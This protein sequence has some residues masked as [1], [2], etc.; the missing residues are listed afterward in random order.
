MHLV[1]SRAPIV[2]PPQ[3]LCIPALVA[4]QAQKTPEALAILAPGRSPLTYGRL[5]QHVHEVIPSLRTLGIGCHNRVALVLPNG[6]EMAVA[7]LAISAGAT[8]APLNPAYGTNDFDFALRAVR[9]NTLLIQERVDSPARAVAHALGVRIVEL[10]PRLDAEAGL[11]TLASQAPPQAAPQ[12]FAQ[13]DDVALVLHTTGTT[14]QPKG[15]PLTH[16]NVCVSAYNTRHALALSAR[17][18]CLNVMPLFHAHGLMGALLAS[19]AAGASV[20]CTPGFMAPN[21]FDWVAEYRPTWYTAVPTIHQAI[22]ARAGVHRDIITRCPL[23]FIR[24]GSAA[25]SPDILTQ[26]ETTFQAPVIEYY[27]MT[28]AASQIACNP[29][30]PQVRKPGSVGVAAGPEVAVMDESGTFVPAGTTGEIIIRGPNVMPGYDRDPQA[31]YNAFVSGWFRTGDQGFL[32][33][34]GY[35]FITGRLKEIINRGGEKI[36]PQEVEAVLMQHPAVAQAIAFAVPE[37]RLGEEVAAVVVLHHGTPATAH[38]LRHF[39]ATRL[40]AWKV[41][42]QVCIVEE[43]PRGP[44]GKLQRLHLAAQLGLTAPADTQLPALTDYSPART[45]IEEMLVGL[46]AQMLEVERVGRDDDFFAL[47]G[48]SILATQL[49]VRVREATQVEVSHLSFFEAPTVAGMARSIENAERTAGSLPVPLLQPVLKHDALPLSYP[50]QR[51]WFLEQMGVIG[52]AY[53]LVDAIRLRG[54]LNIMALTQSLQEILSRHAILRTTFTDIEG[55]PRQIIGPVTSLSLSMVDMRAFHADTRETQV[56][57][58]AQAEARRS[59]DLTQGPLLRTTLVHCA[60][61]ESVLILSMHHIVSDGWSHGVWWRELAALYAAFTAGKPSPLPPLPVQYADFAV[62]QRQWIHGEALR[63]S[64]AYWKRHLA[65]VTTLQ[66]P[67]DHPRPPVKT[68]RGARYPLTLSSTLTQALKE[69]SQ[70][71]GRTLFMT[72]LAAF[73]T[74]LHRYTGQEDI[75]VGSLIANRSLVA[76]EALIGFFVNTI[77]LRTD[78][79]GDPSFQEL[80]ARIRAVTLGAYSHRELPFEMLLEELRPPRDLSKTPLFQVLFVLQNAPRSIPALA[81]LHVRPVEVDPTTAR[82]DLTLDL[83]ETS[84]GLQG[85][86]EYSTDLFEATTIARMAGHLQTLLEGVVADPAQCLSRLPLSRV[87]ERQ[88]LLVEWNATHTEYPHDQCLHEAFESQV[89]RTPNA[90]AIGGADGYLSYSELNRR[91]NQV[92]HMLRTLD[93]GAETLVGLCVERSLLM[94][95]GL[96][97]ILKAGAG[98]VPLDPTYP[99]ERIA[100]ML[101][102]LRCPWCYHKPTWGL[103]W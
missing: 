68:F 9:A 73:Q 6:P 36:A 47:G 71:Y 50:Q 39:A 1:S 15:V 62:W 38:A 7:C 91:A 78:C 16:T 89:L 49:I 65:G 14:A 85:W 54:P 42:R 80:L 99:A 44:S 82:F 20:V 17:D 67:T 41:P 32:D 4:A 21:F 43:I 64:L 31:N 70:R 37:V 29:L 35:L 30:P 77:V 81:G 87:E 26:L 52:H 97:G 74:L 96:L 22:L 84:A 101:Q 5:H 102:V 95:V 24:S 51:L 94:V 18:R 93:V 83:I 8:C 13:P 59:F 23:R 72:L 27:G 48:D 75:V 12:E 28:E 57:A 53:T 34:D 58:I 3:P 79:S 86:F 46:W 55:K 60:E 61:D 45:P 33:P 10:S 69:L 11:F 19:L 40:A 2:D 92:A 76:T 100:F 90:I 66:L 88:Q 56:H 63:S 98:Y 103:V 25:L